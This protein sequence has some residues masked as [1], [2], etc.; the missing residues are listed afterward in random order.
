MAFLERARQRSR[1]EDALRALEES[2]RTLTAAPEAATACFN[3]AVA[4]DFLGLREA[5]G[6][7]FRRCAAAEPGSGWARESLERAALTPPA[8]WAAGPL[9]SGAALDASLRALETAP[10]DRQESALVALEELSRA[11][12][13]AWHLDVCGWLRQGPSTAR[14]ARIEALRLIRSAKEMRGQGRLQDAAALLQRIDRLVAGSPLEHDAGLQRAILEYHALR[15]DAALAALRALSIETERLHYTTLQASCVRMRGL[16]RGLSGD[17]SSAVADHE[18]AA[19]LLRAAGDEP[20]AAAVDQLRAEALWYLG[21]QA[22]A[23]DARRRAFQSLSSF[24]PTRRHVVLHEAA[25]AALAEGF[26]HA[27]ERLARFD[28]T[29]AGSLPAARCDALVVLARARAA[30]KDLP[31]SRAALDRARK[32][33]SAAG[34]PQLVARMVAEVDYAQAELGLSTGVAN[35]LSAADRAVAFFDA[36]RFGVRAARLR[37]IRSRLRRVRGD[38]RGAAG[39]LQEGIRILDTNYPSKPDYRARFLAGSGSELYEEQLQLER[40][41]GAPQERLFDLA[42]H[43][44]ARDYLATSRLQPLTQAEVRARLP[45]GVSLLEFSLLPSS[46]LVWLADREQA[47]MVELR[48]GPAEVE[49]EVEQFRSTV[50]T[51]NTVGLRRSTPGRL[52]RLLGEVVGALPPGRVLAIV[53]DGALGRLP[54]AALRHARSGRFLVE[55]HRLAVIPSASALLAQQAT[56]DH[57]GRGHT[58]LVVQADNEATGSA[59]DLP[60][61]AQV[62]REARAVA[63]LYAGSRVVPGPELLHEG[64]TAFRGSSVLH[65]AGHAIVNEVFPE[66]SRLALDRSGRNVVQASQIRQLDLGGLQVVFLSACSTAEGQVVRGEG[67]LSLA[68]SFLLAGARSVVATLWDVSDEGAHTLAIAFHRHLAGGASAST[69]L[70]RAQLDTLERLPPSVWAGFVL[71]GAPQ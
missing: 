66:L 27:G 38:A 68:R 29:E 16:I 23:W 51:S 30:M 2:E 43:G 37:L 26:P 62:P 45:A 64:L 28:L 50:R 52:E 31:G 47:R 20:A 61:L 32:S 49:S 19:A 8:R 17:L 69:A 14:T 57:R 53:P 55:D 6:R 11:N 24:P 35:A 39:D 22:R 40:E 54:F 44:R 15:Y 5:A 46:L 4:L 33:A 56:S 71:Y 48:L 18:E 10:D 70:R 60:P 65:F 63:E 36:A 3:Q 13:D 41:R 1:P 7:I 21:E 25:F 58:V 59:A 67:P 42:E 12:R 34:D 9:S